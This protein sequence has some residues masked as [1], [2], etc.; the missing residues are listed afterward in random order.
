MCR[1]KTYHRLDKV[2]ADL[3][4]LISNL[5]WQGDTRDENLGNIDAQL[6]AIGGRWTSGSGTSRRWPRRLPMHHL[7]TARDDGTRQGTRG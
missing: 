5:T 1:H 2:E 6:T 4:A 3:F 7:R